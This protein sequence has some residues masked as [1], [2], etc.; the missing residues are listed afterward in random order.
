MAL[1]PFSRRRVSVC[2]PFLALLRDKKPWRRFWTR[3]DGRKVAR[4]TPREAVAENERVCCGCWASSDEAAETMAVGVDVG[5]REMGWVGWRRVGVDRREEKGRE[6]NA[7]GI[8]GVFCV[9]GVTLCSWTW[10]LVAI[11]GG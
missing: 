5:S 10:L 1:R 6:L 8:V 3:R 2:R 4:R 11:P 7:D 9:N